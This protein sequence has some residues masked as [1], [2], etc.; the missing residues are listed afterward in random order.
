MKKGMYKVLEEELTPK[1]KQIILMYYFD[2][3]NIIQIASELKV[4]KSTISRTKKAA[5]K[6][7]NKI[8]NFFLEVA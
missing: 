2:N 5:E 3:K 8:K 1:Q 4:N 6:K 7:L